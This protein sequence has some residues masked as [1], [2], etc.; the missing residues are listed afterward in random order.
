MWRS[1]TARPVTT[2]WRCIRHRSVT[3][4]LRSGWSC[5]PRR[6]AQKTSDNLG[7]V[8]DPIVGE[9]VNFVDAARP[10]VTLIGPQNLP[11]LDVPPSTG[12]PGDIGGGPG[13][14]GAAADEGRARQPE[15]GDRRDRDRG[16]LWRVR[17]RLA[18]GH[19]LLLAADHGHH[20][21]R[22]GLPVRDPDR[23]GHGDH[24]R[25]FDV[26]Q[27]RLWRVSDG[28][29]DPGG[30][31]VGG[32]HHLHRHR[33]PGPGRPGAGSRSA[34]RLRTAVHADRERRPDR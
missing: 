31:L 18:A 6:S 15:D 24:A 2:R 16:H 8:P 9:V 30:H 1:I 21:Q 20:H 3:G 13:S 7:V 23:G 5:S 28:G 4:R 22:P 19:R 17:Q 10:L 12:D 34:E 25:R 11:I 14:A 32:E 29:D 27:R 33:R 26:H